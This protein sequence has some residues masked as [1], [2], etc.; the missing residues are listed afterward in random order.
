MPSVE[1]SASDLLENLQLKAEIARLRLEQ[2]EKREN[3][4]LFYKPHH[5]QD[6]FHRAGAF[7]RRYAQTGN[8]F[9]KTTMGAAEDSSFALGYR[10]WYSE[11]DPARYAGIPQRPTKG[12]IVVAD[13]GKASDIFTSQAEGPGKGKLFQFIPKEAIVDIKTTHGHISEVHVQSIWGGVSTIHLT[14]IKAY[15]GNKMGQESSSWCWVHIDE[16]CPEQMWKA[17]ARG[18]VD[19]HGSAWFTCTPITEPWI[20][21]LFN[22]S[23]VFRDTRDEGHIHEVDFEGEP[24]KFWMITGSMHDNGHNSSAAKAAFIAELSEEERKTR[25]DGRPANLTGVVYPQ[26]ERD[27]HL[28]YDT[29]KGWL[30]FDLPPDNYTLRVAIDTHPSTPHAVLLAATAPTGHTFIFSEIFEKLYV[31]ALCDRIWQ[32]LGGRYP[33]RALLEQAAYNESP[34]E[35]SLTLADEFMNHPMPLPVEP[36]IKDPYYGI[37]KVQNLL[38]KRDKFGKPLI[39]FSHA[40]HETI[41]EFGRY[42]WNP[43]KPGKVVDKDDHMMENLYRLVLTG[44]EYVEPEEYFMSDRQATYKNSILELP[45]IPTSLVPF[46]DSPSTPPLPRYL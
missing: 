14:T 15:K 22:P 8:R 28:Y 45:Y 21:D 25:I 40:C 44:L 38:S 41:R 23:G 24:I 3:G 35:G 29:P 5:K 26:F 34:F 31:P 4:L 13:W 42:V 33:L 1:N 10:P 39:Y 30:D 20:N 27:V 46:S 16:P 17:I 9:G 37:M 2:N 19:R 6:L 11:G 32:R 12:L 7:H 36:A 43:D 18:L